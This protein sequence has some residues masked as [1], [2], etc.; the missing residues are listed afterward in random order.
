[1]IGSNQIKEHMEI[2]GSDGMHVGTVDH[3]E[4]GDQIKLTRTDSADGKHHFISLDM[5]ESVDSKVHLKK[6]GKEVMDSLH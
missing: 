2:V 3:M 6:A 4:E 1:M 5:V